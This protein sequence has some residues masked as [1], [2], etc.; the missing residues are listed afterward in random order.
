VTGS[1]FNNYISSDKEPISSDKEPIFIL[2]CCGLGEV[3]CGCVERSWNCTPVNQHNVV[4]QRENSPGTTSNN[5]IFTEYTSNQTDNNNRNNA[6]NRDSG[7][8]PND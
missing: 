6:N 1:H 5:N 7:G 8:D 3:E 4:I 2:L